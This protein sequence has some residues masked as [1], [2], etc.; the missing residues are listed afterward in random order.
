MGIDT[1]NSHG[2]TD[3]GREPAWCGHSVGVGWAVMLMFRLDDV[4]GGGVEWR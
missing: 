3:E 4:C 2:L 1:D